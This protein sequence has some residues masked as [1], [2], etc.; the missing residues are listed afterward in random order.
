MEDILDD[1]RV[2]HSPG[3]NDGSLDVDFPDSG[4]IVHPVLG[5]FVAGCYS[6]KHPDLGPFPTMEE[7][8]R[9]L[10]EQHGGEED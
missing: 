3:T 5:G 10:I 9:T 7:A 4:W 1:P 6:S 8:V 2:S